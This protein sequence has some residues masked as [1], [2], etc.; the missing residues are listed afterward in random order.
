VARR[1]VLLLSATALCALVAADGSAARNLGRLIAPPSACPGQRAADAPAASQE[2][3]MRCM[4]NYARRRANRR[5]LDDS[6][7]LDTSAELKSRD[8][9]RCHS[10]S[11]YACGRAFT[12]WIERVGYFESGCWRVGENI[13]WGSGSYS[14]VRSIFSA[15]IDSPSHRE[16]ILSAGYDNLGVGLEVGGLEGYREAHVWVQHFG[17]HC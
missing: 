7:K 2:R 5:R 15:W 17:E 11:H 1:I 14:S 6:R 3:A 8:I 13:A 9:V 4:T 12:Y 10:F 16:N